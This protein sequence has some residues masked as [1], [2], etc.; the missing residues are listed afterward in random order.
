MD[1]QGNVTY[2]GTAQDGKLTASDIKAIADYVTEADLVDTATSKG[3]AVAT[4]KTLSNGY[5]YI[6]TGLGSAVTITSTNPNAKVNDKNTTHTVD[7]KITGASEISADGKKA[8]EQLGQ[9]VTY[10]ATIH[11]GKGA[12][13]LKFHDKMTTGLTFKTGSVTVTGTDAYE[14]LATPEKW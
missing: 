10:T 3:T 2:A 1:G 8:L 14:I 9:D 6:A 7:K 13:N 12:T 4:S 11:V 5:Y